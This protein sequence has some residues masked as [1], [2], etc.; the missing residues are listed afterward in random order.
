MGLG[1]K[2]KGV[3]GGGGESSSEADDMAEEWIDEV[4]S[5]VE[6]AD[7]DMVPE[8]EMDTEPEVRE[9]DTAY[10]FAAEFLEVRGFASM[11]DFGN[12]CMAYRI[13]QS[14]KYRD[15]IANGV[16]TMNRVSSMKQQLEQVSGGS[17]QQKGM[18]EKAEELKAANDVIDQAQKLSGE[19]DAMVRDMIGLGEDLVNTLAQNGGVPSG[20]AD[21]N[22][23]VNQRNEEM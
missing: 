7:E 16:D 6:E 8:G 10:Q 18:K 9:W 20:N 1:S 17:Q 5:E 22:A 11:A 2:I 3:L 12:K 21:V 14:P 4:D 15:R 19:E 23:N 13:N